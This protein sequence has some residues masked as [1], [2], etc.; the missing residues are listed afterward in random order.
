LNRPDVRFVARQGHDQFVALAGVHDCRSAQ[1][2]KTGLLIPTSSDFQAVSPVDFFN[3]I[4]EVARPAVKQNQQIF[5][6]HRAA[7]IS[8]LGSIRAEDPVS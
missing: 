1:D 6:E 7:A 8:H 3:A 5:I 4:K 2:P